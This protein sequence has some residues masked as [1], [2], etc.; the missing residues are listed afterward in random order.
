MRN[1]HVGYDGS[2]PN[3]AGAKTSALAALSVFAS[4]LFPP[5]TSPSALGYRFGRAGLPRRL[6]RLRTVS[7]LG[8]ADVVGVQVDA[9]T[10]GQVVEKILD[11]SDTTSIHVAV[12]VNAHVCNLAAADRVLGGDLAISDLNYA[13]G[14]SVVW[15]A[16]FLGHRIPERVATTDLIYPLA[17]ACA[18]RD[19]KI[20]LYGGKPGV[21]EQAAAVLSA[22]AP[23]LRTESRDGYV[24]LEET[25]RLIREINASGASILLVGLGDPLQQRW[26]SLHR[27]EL[28][29]PVVLTCGGLFDHTSG[30]HRRAPAWLIASGLE[31]FWRFLL[32]PRRLAKRYLL[33]NPAFL[34]RLGRQLV[35]DRLIAGA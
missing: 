11:W 8:R 1:T 21:A 25:T 3:H 5:M 12:G 24:T 34:L 30:A 22:A 35:H 4:A 18:Q 32:E 7:R 10:M 17:V 13:D 31:W 27:G 23:G 19:K 26:V 16:R 6:R 15:A 14:Q 33:G 20:F 9:L 29:V 28:T 2:P